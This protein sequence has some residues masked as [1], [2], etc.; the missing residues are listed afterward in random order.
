MS[1][2]SWLSVSPEYQ[3]V[4]R[5]T[6]TPKFGLY[7]FYLL[8]PGVRMWLLFYWLSICDFFI[9]LLKDIIL[10]AVGL[11][12]PHQ[13]PV[14]N[15][16]QRQ[17][18][19]EHNFPPNKTLASP[20]GCSLAVALLWEQLRFG[21]STGLLILGPRLNVQPLIATRYS[22]SGEQK[23]REGGENRAKT[24]NVFKTFAWMWLC[25]LLILHW[26]KKFKWPIPKLMEMGNNFLLLW[27]SLT[28]AGK[29][30]WCVETSPYWL[31]TANFFISGICPIGC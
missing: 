1:A 2:L 6:S 20:E 7:S 17:T 16:W 12:N 14:L 26:P 30:R 29:S 18:Q 13:E 3:F 28:L 19:S 24:Y 5:C 11:W 27:E 21:G 9:S 25:H 22:Q 10:F 23:L 4:Q 31:A 8:L 15:S